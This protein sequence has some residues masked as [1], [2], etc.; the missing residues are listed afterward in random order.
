VEDSREERRNRRLRPFVG[1][2]AGALERFVGD[3]RAVRRAATVVAAVFAAAVTFAVLLY[4][5]TYKRVTLVVDGRERVVETT[6]ADVRTLLA[7]EGINVRPYDRLSAPYG[8][9]LRD[10]DR[11]GLE[12]ARPVVVTVDGMTRTVYTTG[13]TVGEALSQLAVD[14]DEHDRVTP[15]LAAELSAD[16]EIRVVRVE[17][18]TVEI[19]EALPFGTVRTTDA[20]LP[21]GKER[22]VRE[23][24]SGERVKTVEKVYED[25]VLVEE[26]VVA[27]KTVAQPVDR[28]IAVGT[29]QPVTVLSADDENE[30]RVVTKGGV[31]FRYVRV[32]NNV[33]LTAYSTNARAYPGG[34]WTGI[35][36]TGTKTTEG[37]TIAV[38]PDVIP[39]GWWVYIEGIGFRRAEDTGG[40][41]RGN[42]I[43]IYFDNVDYARQFGVKRGYKVYVIGKEKP[44]AD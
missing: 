13:K 9:R 39:L 22:L 29:K 23:G 4:G 15:D 20:T 28:V 34:Q 31:T 14:L 27:E 32:L 17:K 30:A 21:K 33:T 11:I 10:G 6:A 38:D 43:D 5:T 8:A 25:G 12:R 37:R 36:A 41:I 44:A 35:T 1:R 3:R 19:R 7:E 42:K 2:V 24:R 18:E 26:K 40:A 16:T